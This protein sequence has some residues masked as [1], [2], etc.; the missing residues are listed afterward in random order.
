YFEAPGG[1]WGAKGLQE[2]GLYQFLKEEILKK[3]PY[4]RFTFFLVT[5]RREVQVQGVYDHVDSCEKSDFA[6]YLRWLENC[7]HEIAYHGL[8]HGE[9][10]VKKFVQEWD[11]YI[12]QEAA[13]SKVRT[14]VA[15]YNAALDHQ[16]MGGK[17][18][19]YAE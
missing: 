15:L 2:D 5:G 6:R 10:A 7:G 12:S 1:D 11:T 4:V 16:P 3:Y 18:C 14:G 8:T 9:V 13:D 17:Y 19:G